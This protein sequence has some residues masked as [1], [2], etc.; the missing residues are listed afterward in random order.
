MMIIGIVGVMGV[1]QLGADFK[2]IMRVVFAVPASVIAAT[3]IR[4]F[5]PVRVLLLL[6]N[7]R[8]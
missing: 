6:C 3:L 1:N 5:F 7:G 4:Y 2:Y 8:D